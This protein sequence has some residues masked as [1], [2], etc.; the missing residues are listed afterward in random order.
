M[1]MIFVLEEVTAT[2]STDFDPGYMGEHPA[3]ADLPGGHEVG[4]PIEFNIYRIHNITYM[5]R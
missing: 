2:E 1:V 5:H 4:S 3:D